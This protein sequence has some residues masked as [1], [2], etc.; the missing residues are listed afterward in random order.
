MSASS[1]LLFTIITACTYHKC[2]QWKGFQ[3][4]DKDPLKSIY[5]LNFSASSKEVINEKAFLLKERSSKDAVNHLDGMKFDIYHR[6]YDIHK[7]SKEFILLK[8]K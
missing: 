7:G 3:V 1:L 6:S 4:G 8:W 2:G 5:N